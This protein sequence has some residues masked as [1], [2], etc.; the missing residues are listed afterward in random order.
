MATNYGEL[1]TLVSEFGQDSGGQLVA[2]I[3]NFIL[4]AEGAIARDVRA[5]ELVTT[6]TLGETDRSSGPIY[7]LPT[8]FLGARAVTGTRSS[9]GYMLKP[10][11][12]A[13]LYSYGLSGTPQVYSIYGDLIEFRASP[14]VNTDFTLIYYARPA[15]F[16]ADGDTND[17][18][19]AYPNLYLKAAMVELHNFL[20]DV[21]LAQDMANSYIS[22]VNQV[23][24]LAEETRGS[25]GVKNA[26]NFDLGGTM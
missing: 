19:N 24:A 12:I 8:D 6:A 13:E 18:L 5:V 7:S 3:P 20:Q 10:V 2:D 15:I 21:E 14:A 26:F 4:L 1:K 16:S 25:G 23:N 9:A 22:D 11:A 17:L